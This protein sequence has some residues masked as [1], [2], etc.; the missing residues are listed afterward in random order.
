MLPSKTGDAHAGGGG[1]DGS[2]SGFS[3]AAEVRRSIVSRRRRVASISAIAAS[4]RRDGEAGKDASSF[5]SSLAPRTLRRNV[6]FSR[7]SVSFVSRMCFE[8]AMVS[9][10]SRSKVSAS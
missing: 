7:K 4:V 9:A 8:T 1:N 6:R 5:S 3:Y 2:A 10:K